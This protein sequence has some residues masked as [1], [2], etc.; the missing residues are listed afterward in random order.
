M[1][2]Q[3]KEKHQTDTEL[4]QLHT[5][6]RMGHLEVEKPVSYKDPSISFRIDK[7]GQNALHTAKRRLCFVAAEERHP[8]QF[9]MIR[10]S[11]NQFVNMSNISSVLIA[12]WCW[13]LRS[14]TRKPCQKC[15]R[16]CAKAEEKVKKLGVTMHQL[17]NPQSACGSC[18]LGLLVT[19][20]LLDPPLYE[21][22]PEGDLEQIVGKLTTDTGMAE[23][24]IY[25]RIK[26]IS[27][28]NPMLGFRGCSCNV[29]KI[30]VPLV[31]TPQ[32]L[33]HQIG[34]IRGVATKVF[35]EMRLSL[36]YKVGTMIE[37]PR[38][39]LIAL[40]ADEIAKDAEF[41]S[42]GTNDLTQM[43]FG[44]SRDDVGKFLLVYLAQGILQYD[45]FEVGSM[46]YSIST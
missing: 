40:I 11:M 20:R 41:F 28:V 36:E 46:S 35:T 18:E 38:A 24:E 7:K 17:E 9:I 42:F 2:N 25:S 27:E 3:A 32:E 26:K 16:G 44:F 15:S 37:I 23:D 13:R 19:I 45:P 12:L 29:Y 6:T 8:N 33:R 1:V 39:A 22:L 5:L 4:L 10:I 14:W 21:F 43:T 30:M 31:G 34:V